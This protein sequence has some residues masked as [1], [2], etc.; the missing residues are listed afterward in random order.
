MYA[1]EVIIIDNLLRTA[2]EKARLNMTV[3]GRL[4]KKNKSKYWYCVAYWT[5]ENGEQHF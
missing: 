2:G 4:K 1:K 5:D 3:H